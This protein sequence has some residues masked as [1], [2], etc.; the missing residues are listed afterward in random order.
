MQEQDQPR[1][2]SDEPAAE[3]MTPPPATTPPPPPPP[4]AST[5]PPPATSD[6]GPVTA[7]TARP[8]GV[9]I[10]AVLAAIGGLLL[11]LGSLALLATLPLFG[12]ITLV[13]A[14][15]YL[16]LAWGL[17]T[18]QPWAWMLGVGLSIISIVL[19]IL[20]LLQGQQN[21]VG[22]LISVAISGVILYYLYTP[23]VKA[24]FG[25]A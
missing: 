3:P 25:R 6:A 11:L 12:I 23:G 24:A 13:L 18:L 7:T 1:P 5:A 14:V 16:G 9:T 21:I 10:L 15:L 20:Q 22:A 4:A 8:T 2:G 19:T 17:W